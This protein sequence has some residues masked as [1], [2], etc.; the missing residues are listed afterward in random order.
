MTAAES[1]SDPIAEKRP[2]IELWLALSR[3]WGDIFNANTLYFMS[4][5]LQDRRPVRC[6]FHRY[7]VRMKQKQILRDM[8]ENDP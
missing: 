5:L 1:I 8:E 3:K 4:C 7:Q 2:I 6:D